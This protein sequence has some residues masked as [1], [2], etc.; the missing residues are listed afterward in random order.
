RFLTLPVLLSLESSIVAQQTGASLSPK[1]SRKNSL[2]FTFTVTSDSG[3]F[4]AVSFP[5][6]KEKP[7]V[8][9]VENS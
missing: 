1:F 4:F 6:G 8:I 5:C 2:L 3:R 7:E 9:S